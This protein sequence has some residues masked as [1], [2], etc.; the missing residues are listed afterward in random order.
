MVRNTTSLVALVAE[1]VGIT[2]LPQLSVPVDGERLRFLPIQGVTDL[3]PLHVVTRANSSPSPA[4]E[5]FIAA[6]L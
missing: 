1:G 4:A 3:R 6:L 5:A 2:I